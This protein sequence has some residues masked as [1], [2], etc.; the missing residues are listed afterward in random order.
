MKHRSIILSIIIA[1]LIATA[2]GCGQKESPAIDEFNSP[3]ITNKTAGDTY[4]EAA[5]GAE[6]AEGVDGEAYDYGEPAGDVYKGE[7]TGD[8]VP[9]AT[10]DPSS[11]S[12][13]PPVTQ[14]P[15]AGQLTAG[16]WS[17]ND[18]WGFFTNLVNTDLI[19]FPSYG[20]NPCA[21]TVVTVKDKDG[22]PIA[23]AAVSLLNSSN[24]II[25]RSLTD[26][27][28]KAYLF[29][30]ENKSGTMV[31]AELDGKK[32]TCDVQSVKDDKQS[33][34]KS[35]DSSAEIVFDVENK[36]YKNT[37]IMFIV[38]ATG[39]MSDEM[40]FLQS[41]FTAITNELG[42]ENTRYAV[43]FYRDVGDD[44]VTKCNE[45]TSDI[46][47]LQNVLNS[48][49]ANGGGDTPE[50]VADI[51]NKSVNNANWDDESVKL[52]FLIFDAPPHK[53]TEDVITAAVKEASAKGIHIVPV[54]S[55]NSERDTELFGRA[56]AIVT[57]GQYVFLT[58][59]SGIGDS[60]L[61][62]IIGYYEVRSL[63][64]III[65]IVNEYR[66]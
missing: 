19:S 32:Q 20:L 60:H 59:D 35:S 30:P 65:D 21:R 2:A 24:E 62:P 47:T 44:Y 7:T 66:Q 12:S 57:N 50:A 54:V 52:A 33:N 36:P 27:N 51:L 38:D 41:E 37:D 17:D 18:N 49:S 29:S 53:G 13:S 25:W 61:E 63:Y 43:N 3:T 45:F 42:T 23:N 10:R 14:P 8:T 56:L 9:A 22:K 11:E 1:A 39:S 58:D 40:V 4:P 28:G 55:S 31:E 15:Q 6:G 46:K 26:K 64:D 34:E 48:E 5:D 16:V